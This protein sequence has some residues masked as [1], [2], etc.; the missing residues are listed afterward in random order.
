VIKVSDTASAVIQDGQT[1]S[2]K[3]GL[4]DISRD[5]LAYLDLGCMLYIRS[6]FFKLGFCRVAVCFGRADATQHLICL[7]TEG[8]LNRSR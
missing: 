7:E 8:W 4:E 2:I 5:Q 6:C 3:P 1:S